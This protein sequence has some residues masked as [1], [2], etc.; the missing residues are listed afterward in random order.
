MDFIHILED[1]LN[2][3]ARIRFEPIQPGDV[4]ETIADIS[5]TQKDLQFQP[6]TNI[7]EGLE[8]TVA[9]YREFYES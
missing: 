7:R 6:K 5:E 1:L 4:K 3:K 8:K 2:V 9:W